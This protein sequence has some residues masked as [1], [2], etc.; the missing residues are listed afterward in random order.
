MISSCR[1]STRGVAVLALAVLLALPCIGAGQSKTDKAGTLRV[2]LERATK[3]YQA[4]DFKTAAALYHRLYIMAPN[5]PVSLYNAARLE[6]KMGQ[7]E[8]AVAH[9]REFLVVTTKKHPKRALAKARFEAVTAKLDAARAKAEVAKAREAAA[10][11]GAADERREAAAPAAGAVETA[12]GGQAA[13]GWKRPAGWGAAIVGGLALVGGGVLLAMA[14]GD[15]GELDDELAASEAAHGDPYHEVSFEQAEQRQG[16]IDSSNTLGV[17]A[18]AGG[19]V[20]AGLGIWLL[21]TDSGG[22]KVGFLP[23][24]GGGGVRLGWRF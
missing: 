11:R 22:A 4:G 17:S 8:P 21:V 3:A 19:A 12:P 20:V 10:E 15:K 2:F 1:L 7:L 9:Y 6:E 16:D 18:L 5:R 24:R 13:G 23:V 14:S